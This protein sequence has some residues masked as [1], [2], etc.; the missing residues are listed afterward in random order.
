[1]IIDISNKNKDAIEKSFQVVVKS[2]NG[3][4]LNYHIHASPEECLNNPTVQRLIETAKREGD[5]YF[6]TGRDDYTNISVS[7][8]DERIRRFMKREAERLGMIFQAEE[9]KHLTIQNERAG[10]RHFECFTRYNGKRTK[11]RKI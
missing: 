6:V 10:V 2:M 4:G 5:F 7:R 11:N 1:M 8:N 9:G 3:N